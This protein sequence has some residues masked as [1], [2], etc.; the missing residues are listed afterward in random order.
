MKPIG[1]GILVLAFTGLALALQNR[2]FSRKP[3]RPRRRRPETSKRSGRTPRYQKPELSFKGEVKNTKITS[4]SAPDGKVQKTELSEP[5]S[6][7]RKSA[8]YAED[9]RQE[10]RLDDPANKVSLE[11][12]FQSLPD[13]TNTPPLPF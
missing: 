11:V 4:C 10:D 8:A 7:R 6:R 1:I 2:R 12:N 13:G 9:H 5:P 3:L